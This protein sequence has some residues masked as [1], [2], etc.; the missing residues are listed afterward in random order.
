MGI[1]DKL[2][3]MIL[4]EK[5][6]R[7]QIIKKIKAME[8][9]DLD[10]KILG[11]MDSATGQKLRDQI[12]AYVKDLDAEKMEILLTDTLQG[13]TGE[14]LRDKVVALAETVVPEVLVSALQA[15]LPAVLSAALT[16]LPMDAARDKALELIGQIDADLLHKVAA[17][18]L[19]V[20]SP[21]AKRACL[22][23]WIENVPEE[24][25]DEII[26]SAL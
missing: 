7:A 23:A 19:P 1:L 13:Q 17:A 22:V 11:G 16:M 2:I 6:K 14:H 3:P 25:L 24:T 21:E 4:S 15:E 9:D 10:R 18:L 20:I 8:P 12:I 26:R 5:R